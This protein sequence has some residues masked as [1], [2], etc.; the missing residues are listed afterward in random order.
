MGG[1]SPTG[2]PSRTSH[3]ALHLLQVAYITLPP[4]RK[5]KINT[6][7]FEL[8]L[9]SC[10]G[11]YLPPLA[12]G[13]MNRPMSAASSEQFGEQAFLRRQQLP[14]R[15]ATK[16]RRNL[17][18]QGRWIVDHAVPNPIYEAISPQY[19]NMGYDDE[20]KKL[21][22]T[23][24]CEDANVFGKKDSGYNLRQ[25]LS[26]RE[27]IE[28]VICV[29]SY[30]EGPDLCA[31]T[32]HGVFKNI[33]DIC[34]MKSSKFWG[35]SA[36]SGR[37]AWQKIVVVLVMDGL[38]AADKGTLD[39]LA[40][41]GC[42]QDGLMKSSVNGKPVVV[43]MFEST[44]QISVSFNNDSAPRLVLPQPGAKDNIPPVQVCLMIKHEN[45]KK[46]N[47][48]R[49]VFNGFARHI[50][51]NVIVLLD[52]GTKPGPLSIYRLWQ[53]FYNEKWLGGCAGEIRADIRRG[54][55]V[56]FASACHL[57]AVC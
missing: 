56:R 9:H 30:N 11:N 39:L 14:K 3:W 45:A 5:L 15:G 54:L 23:A 31:R 41:M 24:I 25:N 57:G 7:V 43:S 27:D 46:I 13:F 51:P 19:R 42:Y 53:A 1:I 52:A 18:K 40:T 37:P 38:K 34:N 36:E 12:F 20:F 22:Y 2:I 4:F 44:T 49:W 29:T 16:V 32:I 33:R 26:G 48:H 21:R 55:K 28:L 17:T 50:N 6:K 10:S 47:S 8:N 35:Q